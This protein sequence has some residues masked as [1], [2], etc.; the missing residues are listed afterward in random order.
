MEQH[1]RQLWA[2]AVAAALRAERGV[3][4]LSQADVE[5]ITGI[6]RSSYRYYELATRNPD[7]V[8]IA[9]IAEAFGISFSRLMGE[10]DRRGPVRKTTVTELRPRVT[11]EDLRGQGMTNVL[12]RSGPPLGKAALARARAAF[13]EAGK[14][15]RTTERFEILTLSGWRK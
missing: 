15:G 8:Q 5:R 1:E 12:A 3:A 14:D 6:A 2:E 10:I 4:G 7:V 11:V 13:A 9:Q